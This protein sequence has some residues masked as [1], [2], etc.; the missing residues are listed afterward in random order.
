MV[1]STDPLVLAA[2]EAAALDVGVHLVE[3]LAD[4]LPADPSSAAPEPP[5]GG[6]H[7]VTG[8][9]R[10]VRSRGRSAA[11]VGPPGRDPGQLVGA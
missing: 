10:V 8:R 9:F 7:F 6:A 1:H 2:A 5:G 11:A 3:N 4:D